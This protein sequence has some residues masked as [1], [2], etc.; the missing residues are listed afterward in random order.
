MGDTSGC[1]VSNSNLAIYLQGVSV[2]PSSTISYDYF[3]TASLPAAAARRRVWQFI[4]QG[5]ILGTSTLTLDYT[6]A[7]ENCKEYN[8]TFEDALNGTLIIHNQTFSANKYVSY[9]LSPTNPYVLV[10]TITIPKKILQC[11][12]A[13]PQ[14]YF[15]NININDGC[16]TCLCENVV[17][18]IPY[19]ES[20]TGT[21]NSECTQLSYSYDWSSSGNTG[22]LTLTNLVSYDASSGTPNCE[23]SCSTAACSCNTNPTPNAENQN[24]LFCISNVVIATPTPT[25]PTTGPTINVVNSTG[26]TLNAEQIKVSYTFTPDGESSCDYIVNQASTNNFNAT[27]YATT[28]EY[29]WT[30]LS[31]CTLEAI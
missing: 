4:S 31:G 24:F 26:I 7:Y 9:A 30:D 29:S 16:F 1:Q 22:T 13:K 11:Y 19:N 25:T 23:S 17:Q 15:L 3:V 27:I 5:T 12:G 10:L 8:I 18:S 6:Q 21:N 28:S 20:S 14:P 2:D